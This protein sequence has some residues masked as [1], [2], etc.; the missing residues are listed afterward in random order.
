MTY[1]TDLKEMI[2]KDHYYGEFGE[3]YRTALKFSLDLYQAM[4]K[5]QTMETAPRDGTRILLWWKTC[6]SPSVGWYTFDDFGEGF[7]CDG[8]ECIPHNQDDCTHWRPLPPP[9]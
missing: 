5:W 2:A 1:E 7:R 6:T 3:G 8:D 4:E 9:P